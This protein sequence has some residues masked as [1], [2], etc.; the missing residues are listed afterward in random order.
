[1]PA[2]GRRRRVLAACAVGVLLLVAGCGDSDEVSSSA[3]T[4]N[5]V[6]RAFVDE[7]VPHHESAIAMAK[8]AHSR[9]SS[10]FVDDLADDIVRT[11]ADEIATMR[12]I[13]RRLE[14][15]G[16]DVGSLGVAHSMMGMDGDVASLQTAKPFD[17]AFMAMMIPHHEGAVVMAKA[18]LAKGEDPELRKLAQAI[19]AAQEREIAAMRDELGE[20][21]DDDASGSDDADD[22]M[23]DDGHSG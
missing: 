5:A 22:A 2:S 20:T 23:H 11:Q 3:T 18:L 17:S 14:A 6:D 8:T 19:V 1:M 10:A 7:M 13:D 16:V 12:E 9:G 4:G 21:A 15:A